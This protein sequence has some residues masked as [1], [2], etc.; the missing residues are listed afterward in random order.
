MISSKLLLLLSYCEMS[1]WSGCNQD[2]FDC[3]V[4]SII[5]YDL[6]GLNWPRSFL[7][8][9]SHKSCWLVRKYLITIYVF[10]FFGICPGSEC[11][12]IIA[13]SVCFH[14]MSNGCQGEYIQLDYKKKFWQIK[15]TYEKYCFQIWWYF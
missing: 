8:W 7:T 2:P 12:E 14:H 4:K 6:T 15:T 1:L 3:W 10:F 13:I 11:M 9:K 5:L